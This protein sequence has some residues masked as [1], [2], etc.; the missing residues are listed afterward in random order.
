V[1][2]FFLSVVLSLISHIVAQ[3]SKIENVL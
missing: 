2:P 1:N 3:G